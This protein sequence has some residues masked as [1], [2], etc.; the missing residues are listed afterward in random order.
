MWE[1]RQ[2]FTLQTLRDFGFGKK[3]MKDNI[4]EEF[5]E[6]ADVWTERDH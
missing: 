4:E 1:T 6:L 2:G 3:G 5:L